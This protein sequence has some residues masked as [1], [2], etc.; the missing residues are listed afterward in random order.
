[1]FSD[2]AKLSVRVG[3]KAPGLA[4]E[5]HEFPKSDIIDSVE[6]RVA[7]IRWLGF[8]TLEKKEACND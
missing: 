8:I 4:G 2:K 5:A 3:R 6:S 7:E 1:L